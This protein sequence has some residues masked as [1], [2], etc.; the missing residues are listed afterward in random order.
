MGTLNDGDVLRGV[1]ASTINAT[2][3]ADNELAFSLT[4]DSLYYLKTAVDGAAGTATTNLTF[5]M[6]RRQVRLRAA[7]WMPEAALTSDNTN[8]ATITVSK[9]P[10]AGG[11]DVVVATGATQITG[12]GS[13]VAGIAVPLVLSTVAGAIIF[14][15]FSSYRFGI[16]KT[17]TGVV[18]GVGTLIV[19]TETF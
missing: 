17:G 2:D 13:F 6:A 12:T 14:E 9:R 16:T 5:G 7:Y 19:V 1:L 4:R 3:A 11:A 18:V 10:A 8:Y 15:Q